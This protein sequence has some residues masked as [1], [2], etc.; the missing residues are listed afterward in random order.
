ML[1]KRIVAVIQRPVLGRHV[2]IGLATR[3][4]VWS[5]EAW[6]RPNETKISHRWRQRALL[7]YLKSKSCENYSSERPA[8]G[9]S[10]RLDRKLASWYDCN[11]INGY[12]KTLCPRVVPWCLC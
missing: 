5:Y 4:V 9:W 12:R 2:V 3:F 7:R 6:H 8:V 1:Q 11:Q 10:V